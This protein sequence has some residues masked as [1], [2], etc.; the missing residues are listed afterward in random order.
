MNSALPPEL[1][2]SPHLLMEESF[3]WYGPNDQ[4][5]LNFIRQT[6]ATAVF[7]ALHEIP[8]GD[9]WPREAIRAR[10]EII[11]KAGLHW[12][13]VES[14]PVHE[15]IRTG[16]GDLDTLYRNYAQTLR[17]LAAEDVRVVIY[18]FMPV[19][20][21]VRTDL[22]HVLPDGSE[23]LQFNPVHFAAFEV[24]ALKRK[25]AEADYTPAQLT[26][27]Q[28]HWESL[29]T[30]QREAFISGLIDVFPGCK[31]GLTLDDLRTMLAKY[32]GIDRDRLKANYAR[33]LKAIVP[34]AEEVGVRLAVHPDDPPFSI[35]GLARVVSTARDVDEV[36]SMVDSPANG[37]CLCAGS[38]SVRADN[39][40]PDM[41][42]RFGPRIHA[43]HLRSTKREADGSFF[44][45]DHLGG[46]VDMYALVR[47]LLEEQDRRKAQG[48]ADCQLAF[49]PDHGHTMMD[50]LGKP[51][52]ANPG[53]TAIGRMRGLAEMR[54]LQVGVRRG[55][56]G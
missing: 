37:L 9:L 16:T 39:N 27:A 55:M 44:E 46:S 11:E 18:N 38:F 40:L 15:D 13:A 56:M 4:V 23:C 19:L 24:H 47:A 43:V 32:D 29:D 30:A 53:Y 45:A 52:V 26:A 34:V 25:G 28:A 3:R 2:T 22:R 12:T 1:Q 21:W 54:G 33:F 10:K 35:L 20:D 6:G 36:F 7:N 41:A 17:N 48:R 31:L 50:D 42:R 8:Y 5:P 49:R 51:P 14:V